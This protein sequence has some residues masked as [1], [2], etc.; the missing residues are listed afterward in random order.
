MTGENQTIVLAMQGKTDHQRD[1]RGDGDA[2]LP[3]IRELIFSFGQM[4][5]EQAWDP[6]AFTNRSLQRPKLAGV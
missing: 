3:A 5:P 4:D 2:M 6:D 1:Y